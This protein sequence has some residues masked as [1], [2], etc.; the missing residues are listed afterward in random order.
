MSYLHDRDRSEVDHLMARTE[1]TTV[2]CP[3][4]MGRGCLWGQ[5]RFVHVPVAGERG[6][7]MHWEEECG[8]CE[9]TGRIAPGLDE[10][11]VCQ[12]GSDA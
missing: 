2:P 6:S 12:A 9:G 5:H 11:P 3:C 8:M 7:T 4:D 1:A 10:Y